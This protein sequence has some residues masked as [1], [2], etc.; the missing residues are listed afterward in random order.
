MCNVN[1]LYDGLAGLN[2][3]AMP[4]LATWRMAIARAPTLDDVPFTK[5][6]VVT[7]ADEILRLGLATGKD[8]KNVPDIVYTFRARADLP[9]EILANGHYAIVGRGKGRY[10]FVRIPRPNRFPAVPAQ[11][12][13]ERVI[14]RV[15][16]WAG[17]YLG[18]DEQ[19]MLSSVNT[20]DLVALHLGLRSA[21]Q[22]QPHRRTTVQGWGQ[23]E[24]DGWYVGEGR[25]ATH[26]G[27]AIEAKDEATGDRLNVSQLFGGAL[28]LR[29][30]F[31]QLQQ[32]L[33]GA[34]PS[35]GGRIMM[36]EFSV[37][38]DVRD[39]REVSE[40]VEYELVVR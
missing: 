18:F 20:N 2:R 31:P 25:D 29:Q 12:R 5:D 21:I 9:A 39:L 32:R 1:M 24:L 3:Y 17:E 19:C 7:Q 35:G 30:D 37:P 15:P 14:S 33:I 38:D 26:V 23:V 40:W 10:A 11:L 36:C 13:R 34:K 28:A 4:L 8:I 27:I 22:L 16:A 6:E